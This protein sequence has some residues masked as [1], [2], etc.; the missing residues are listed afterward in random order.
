MKEYLSRREFLTASV[1]VSLGATA[2]SLIGCRLPSGKQ[3]AATGQRDPQRVGLPRRTLGKT[4]A[5][6]TILGLGGAGFV[7]RSTDKEAVEK[8][9]HEVLDV[10]VRY[11]DTAYS[12]GKN[13]LSEKN[14]GLIMGTPRGR[15]VFL[16]TKCEDR[17]YDGAMKQVAASLARLR[18]DRIDLIQVHHVCPRDT[19]RDFGKKTGVLSALRS[20]RGV[21]EQRP[22]E[23]TTY[24]SWVGVRLQIGGNTHD[25][26]VSA[27][28]PLNR[29]PAQGQ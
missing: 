22:S 8:L 23:E 14:F 11:F 12:Y 16:A 9:L 3:G 18:V 6:V 7:S 15:D 28:N 1:G 10:G 21:Y 4:G 2:F 13:G 17:T 26:V 29:I 5:K 27:A 20:N 19:V 25:Y 24:V